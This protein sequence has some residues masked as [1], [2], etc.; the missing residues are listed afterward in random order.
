MA[1]AYATNAIAAKRRRMV[2]KLMY[3]AVPVN[4]KSA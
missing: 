3:G 2:M 1:T 4:V